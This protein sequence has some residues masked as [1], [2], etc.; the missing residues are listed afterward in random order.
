MYL[1]VYVFMCIYVS[2]HLSMYLSMHL[3]IYLCIYV[4]LCT[5]IHTYT[6]TLT[7]YSDLRIALN[8]Q[9]SRSQPPKNTTSSVSFERWGWV[10]TYELTTFGGIIIHSPAT[11]HRVPGFWPANYPVRCSMWM[12]KRML[13]VWP[14]P[15]SEAT[16]R[17]MSTSKMGIKWDMLWEIRR[18]YIYIYIYIEWEI[19]WNIM[20]YLLG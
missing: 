18:I 6:Y 12:P 4:Y 10:N 15:H 2:M 8:R 7:K 11:V 9:S 17:G 20:S 3:C 5:Y 19:Y 16:N 1:C 14:R 13:S